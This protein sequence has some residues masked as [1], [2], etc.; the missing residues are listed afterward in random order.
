MSYFTINSTTLPKQTALDFMVGKQ[1]LAIAIDSFL[2]DRK[3]RN[4]SP[5]TIRFYRNY[6]NAFEKYAASQ[7]DTSIQ[8]ID[9]TFLRTY[10]LLISQDHNPGGVHGTYR[11]LHAFFLWV[12]KEELM[13][14]EWKNPIHRVD[15]PFVPEKI[16]EPVSYED[17]QALLVTCKDSDFFDKRD[18]SIIFFLL[19]T[20]ARAQEVCDI[21]L[22]DLEL[23][24]GKVIIREGKGRKPRYVFINRT[25]IKAVRAYLRLRDDHQSS[26]L[27]VSKTNERLTYDG[28]RQ[29][30]QRR[31]KVACLKKEPTLHDFRR[32][33]ALSMLNN[34]ADI[35]SLQRLM[36]HK[37][38]SILRRYLAQTT[39]DIRIAHEKCSPVENYQWRS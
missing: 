32:Q 33:F 25:T 20:G 7:G 18:K 19:D 10:L 4:R 34:G 26:A 17:I 30:I 36:G 5:H 37:D 39:E 29:I 27:F 9:A 35:F 24:S 13:P 28:L 31:S 6:L 11:S 22:D 16:I 14:A 15:A 23:N 21:N 38:I 3:S 1:Y 2:N 8:A 12:E